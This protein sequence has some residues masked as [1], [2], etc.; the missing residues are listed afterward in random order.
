MKRT[1]SAT[2][3]RAGG[4]RPS[5]EP[6]R[7][8]GNDSTGTT[9]LRTAMTRNNFAEED[10]KSKNIMAWAGRVKELIG[11]YDQ[12]HDPAMGQLTRATGYSNLLAACGVDSGDVQ[13]NT[14]WPKTDQTSSTKLTNYNQPNPTTSLLMKQ[15]D[16]EKEHAGYP[17]PTYN[18][19]QT[20]QRSTS[21]TMPRSDDQ[22]HQTDRQEL[23]RAASSQGRVKPDNSDAS[24]K[25]VARRSSHTEV[26]SPATRESSRSPDAR[27]QLRRNSVAEKLTSTTERTSASA[28][29]RNVPSTDSLGGHHSRVRLGARTSKE[30]LATPVAVCSFKQNETNEETRKYSNKAARDVC[31]K[32]E[33]GGAVPPRRRSSYVQDVER[34]IPTIRNDRHLN[35]E[36]CDNYAPAAMRMSDPENGDSTDNDET[37]SQRVRVN[38]TQEDRLLQATD[39]QPTN[40]KEAQSRRAS[41]QGVRRCKNGPRVSRPTDVE[42]KDSNDSVSHKVS[43]R[44]LRRYKSGPKM[45][46]PA[47]VEDK[48]SLESLSQMLSDLDMRRRT[49]HSPPVR[50]QRAHPPSQ[51]VPDTSRSN[52]EKPLNSTELRSRRGRDEDFDNYQHEP[53]MSRPIDV[54]EKDSNDSL[55]QTVS[56]RDLR[57]YKNGPNIPQ[58]AE[59]EDKDSLES[60][61][62]MLSDQREIMRETTR[63]RTQYSPPAHLRRAHPPSQRVSDTS[64]SPDREDHAN[65]RDQTSPGRSRRR[66]TSEGGSNRPRQEARDSAASLPPP[67]SADR[68]VRPRTTSAGP[69]SP[70]P[71]LRKASP[72]QSIKDSLTA[73]KGNNVTSESYQP[74]PSSLPPAVHARPA[75][76]PLR[77]KAAATTATVAVTDVDDEDNDNDDYDIDDFVTRVCSGRGLDRR[78]GLGK[79]NAV[80]DL[81]ND[82]RI[83]SHYTS[84]KR[85]QGHLQASSK[86]ASMTPVHSTSTPLTP[87]R[88]WHFMHPWLFCVHQLMRRLLDCAKQHLFELFCLPQVV[89]AGHKMRETWLRVMDDWALFTAVL[90][91]VA[92][93]FLVIMLC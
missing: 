89:E 60:L 67:T 5:P 19:D 18:Q 6:G 91:A 84:G 31:R 72:H 70:R 40:N 7:R 9:N 29:A 68:A 58:P 47:D 34:A 44:D 90:F 71:I 11:T 10:S 65:R 39:E 27:S 57:R 28:T 82:H 15:L 48:E 54:E 69:P 38:D 23:R 79:S 85:Y 46:Q 36:D 93:I 92:C 88:I 78:R 66:L 14:I 4:R 1:A 2:M 73:K 53:K 49:E 16:A 45:P 56:D 62:Q 63:R 55:S 74:R 35:A 75:A 42:K 22:P 86:T 32:P 30:T 20:K 37:A 3:D 17:S 25:P 12:G 8:L 77:R 61:S 52:D 21:S 26:K 64:P 50:L 51:R 43:D 80:T 81:S 83:A 41:D 87:R 13:T 76:V 24:Q 33:S 59:V